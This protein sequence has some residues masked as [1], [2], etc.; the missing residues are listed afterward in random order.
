MSTF[1]IEK[2]LKESIG[3]GAFKAGV[4]IGS[5]YFMGSSRPSLAP[6]LKNYAVI[7][8]VIAAADVAHD[9]AKA[10]KWIPGKINGK[11]TDARCRGSD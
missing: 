5:G 11:S 1:N 10:K 2:E 8:V 9:Y 3:D 6:T 7:A 4:L